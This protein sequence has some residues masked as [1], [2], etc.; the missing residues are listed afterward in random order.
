MESGN[1]RLGQHAPA[2]ERVH[3]LHHFRRGF[4]GECDGQ[5]G[6]RLHAKI[7]DQVR[8]AK[9]DHPRLAAARAGKDQHRAL[10]S[11]HGLALLRVQFV[12][13]VHDENN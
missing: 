4:I 13:K 8:N 10:D 1:Q 3:A 11:F 5:N 12:E 6:I 9:R 7:L 2:D